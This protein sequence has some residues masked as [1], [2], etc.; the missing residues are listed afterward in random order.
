MPPTPAAAPAPATPL[1]PMI[2][3]GVNWIGL[4]TMTMKEVRRF[5][6]VY[7][8]TVIAPVINTALYYVVFSVAFGTQNRGVVEGEPYLTFLLPGLLM[9]G[10][11]QNAFANTSSSFMIAKV[12]GSIVDVLMPPLSA[13]ELLTGYVAGGVLRGICVGLAS[14]L[15]MVP[16]AHLPL[17]NPIL[18]VVYGLLGS[19]FMALLGVLAGIWAEKFDHMAAVTNFVIMP[20]TMLSGTFYS[21]TRLAHGWM[22]LA[23]ANPFFYM[24]DGFRAGFIGHADMP[25]GIGMVM[26]SALCVA[27]WLV[28][29][30]LL[31]SGYKI[32]A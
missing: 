3:R 21:A 19:V 11:A 17:A 28:A 18:I 15:V 4:Y 1:D 30:L 13:G 20:L 29:Y 32:R 23:H 31:K 22:A 5:A 14:V 8:Q 24:I 2:V 6:K 26:L 10:M 12:Q 27:L 16:F 7:W 25:L 9:M